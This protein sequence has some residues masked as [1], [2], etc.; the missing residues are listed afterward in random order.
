[1]MSAVEVK[2]ERHSV[3]VGSIAKG[4]EGFLK[5]LYEGL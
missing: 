4:H 2:T 3:M 1:M 5:F